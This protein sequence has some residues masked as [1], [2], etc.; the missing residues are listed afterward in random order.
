[1]D[2]VYGDH[3][4]ASVREA[5]Q[6]GARLDGRA[7]DEIMNVEMTT[8]VINQASGSVELRMGETHLLAGVKVSLWIYAAVPVPNDAYTNSACRQ[9]WKSLQICT[10]MKELST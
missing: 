4:I 6:A 10:R 1:M 5:A 9:T 8:G 2:G 7:F 3:E